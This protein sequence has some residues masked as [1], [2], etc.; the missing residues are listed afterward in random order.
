MQQS[1][2]YYQQSIEPYEMKFYG[3]L[4]A[5][6]RQ[7]TIRPDCR[8]ELVNWWQ[9]QKYNIKSQLEANQAVFGQ[10]RDVHIE[11][12]VRNCMNGVLA[13]LNQRIAAAQAAYN[14]QNAQVFGNYYQQQAQQ[15]QYSGIQQAL[16]T[17]SVN[18]GSLVSPYSNARANADQ[19][20]IYSS[21]IID[22][23]VEATQS[24]ETV[25]E[26]EVLK[27][28]DDFIEPAVDEPDTLYG[29]KKIEGYFGDLQVTTY[30]DG[31]GN[32]IKY[33]CV[34]YK[35]T[36]WSD[37]DA[38]LRAKRMFDD[39]APYHMDIT[40]PLLDKLPIDY[41]TFVEFVKT[42]RIFVAA[43]PTVNGS[44]KYLK[45]IQA[46]LNK[47]PRGI[48]DIIDKYLCDRFNKFGS[49]SCMSRARLK[50]VK[51]PLVS[52]FANLVELS[53]STDA[54]PIVQV[55]YKDPNFKEQLVLACDLAIRRFFLNITIVD[56]NKPPN[57][58]TIMKAHNGFCESVDY[59]LL[60]V[61]RELYDR[62]I[63]FAEASRE[64]RMNDFGVAGRTLANSVV[65][66]IGGNRVTVTKFVPEDIMRSFGEV[67]GLVPIRLVFGGTKVIDNKEDPNPPV[68]LF[69]YFMI[70]KSMVEELYTSVV[71]E[72][73]NISVKY[74][75]ARSSEGFL[76]LL[77][78]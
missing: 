47:F 18:T 71:I 1:Q 10:I 2:T 21:D 63:K 3:L 43:E 44:L 27:S 28:A 39:S 9:Q 19:N 62:R 8:T 35:D 60:D 15:Y 42:C 33:A 11:N 59:T 69:E 40:Y 41:D 45:L 55:W 58:A 70:H 13:M 61:A 65:F 26:G 52:S 49:K 22:K 7:G 56:P 37:E 23:P 32:I 30:R 36:C 66:I 46:E 76:T 31:Y 54:S 6:I 53:N 78:N 38:I 4:D 74:I 25:I 14:A 75:C 16:Q 73:S 17:P 77:T 50:T 48:A 5:G 67:V 57:M 34:N 29:D 72:S 51:E 24:T 20:N 68:N 12:H 64:S